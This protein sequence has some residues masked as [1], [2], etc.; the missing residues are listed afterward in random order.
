M[1][2]S[3]HLRHVGK[4]CCLHAE[5]LKY[6][7]ELIDTVRRHDV[8]LGDLN[9]MWKHLEGPLGSTY[10]DVSFLPT[11]RA[12]SSIVRG[13][14]PTST[15]S[16]C[17]NARGPWHP[18]RLRSRCSPPAGTIEGSCNEMVGAVITCL[19][20]LIFVWGRHITPSASRRGTW[21]LRGIMRDTIHPRWQIRHR[22]R[23]FTHERNESLASREKGGTYP[24]PVQCHRGAPRSP[25]VPGPR[26]AGGRRRNG[27]RPG[28]LGSIVQGSQRWL[29]GSSTHVVCGRFRIGAS[30]FV[31]HV[32][33]D[34]H[35]R[36]RH[37]HEFQGH[38]A[39]KP[40]N[41]PGILPL[42]TGVKASQLLGDAS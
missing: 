38:R 40:H 28:S 11:S 16:Y 12:R 20:R 18:R 35:S 36:G 42:Q 7:P 27:A 9:T 6:N 21:P 15:T 1:I 34:A 3:T 33:G 19:W 37:A 10:H 17:T 23:I 4:V 25:G 2:L 31:S 39:V 14:R 24:D 29:R 13:I 30:F 22:E 26:A 5:P 8:I 32:R 41:V